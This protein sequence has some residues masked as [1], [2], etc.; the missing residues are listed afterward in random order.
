MHMAAGTCDWNGDDYGSD[1]A[2]KHYSILQSAL[3]TARKHF[4]LNT[5][6]LRGPNAKSLATGVH[7]LNRVL[8]FIMGGHI[9]VAKEQ[10]DAFIAG[11]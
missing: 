5:P 9:D 7:Y 2:A 10:A 4:G 6:T 11:R 1:Q 3:T 8:P